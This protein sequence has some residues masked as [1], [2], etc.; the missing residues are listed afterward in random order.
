M[1]RPLTPRYI[2]FKYKSICHT[3]TEPELLLVGSARGEV[4][5]PERPLQQ[6]RAGQSQAELP[7]PHRAGAQRAL[8]CQP[9]STAP[10]LEAGC[11]DPGTWEVLQ[12]L[13][14]LARG[15]FPPLR[16]RCPRDVTQQKAV[17]ADHHVSTSSLRRDG[18][19]PLPA[20]ALRHQELWQGLDMWAASAGLHGCHALQDLDPV[21]RE[22]QDTGRMFS[23]VFVNW[24]TSIHLSIWGRRLSV[25][26]PLIY[27]SGGSILQSGHL[28]REAG[29]KLRCGGQQCFKPNLRGV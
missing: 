22:M 26:W 25:W 2:Y 16:C 21:S 14:H 3:W 7:A 12:L 18:A 17:V 11:E 19:G 15:I 20:P 4:S 27:Q 23:R 10:A 1:H 29:W 9:R 6:S 24:R 28:F 8:P 5:P 13:S